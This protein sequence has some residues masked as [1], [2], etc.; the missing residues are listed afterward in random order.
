MKVKVKSVVIIGILAVLLRISMQLAMRRIDNVSSLFQE[1]Q[2]LMNK[3]L[4]S[5]VKNRLWVYL[6]AVI[7]LLVFVRKNT[8]KSLMASFHDD[9]S[10]F[11]R[12]L[13]YTICSISLISVLVLIM[14]STS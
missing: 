5:L 9:L 12:C 4:P 11:L 6:I 13:M 1:S 14:Y 8:Y 3:V 2:E 7:Y 10:P